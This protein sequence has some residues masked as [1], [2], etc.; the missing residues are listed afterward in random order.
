MKRIL[1]FFQTHRYAFIWTACYVFIMWAILLFLFNFDMFSGANW[2][3][4][5][6]SKLVGF[7]GFVFGILILA[8]IPLY[9][10]TTL[11]VVRNKSP[12]VK[13]KLPKFLQPVPA[14]AP[15]KPTPTPEPTTAP[16]PSPEKKIP[17]T[18][19]AELRVAYIRALDHMGNIQTS[20]FD[21]S[22]MTNSQKSVSTPDT[23]TQSTNEL[24]LPSDFE[25]PN[26]DFLSEPEMPNFSPMF[27]DLD[28]DSPSTPPSS[29][30]PSISE[31]SP[32]PD[33]AIT[34][35]LAEHGK[36]Y[37]IENGIVITDRDAIAIHDDPDFWIADDVNWFAAGQQKPSPIDT[38]LSI[39][40]ARGVRPVLYLA[41]TNILDLDAR[42]AQW[43]QAGITTITDLSEL[44]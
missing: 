22:N 11:I 16:A 26:E 32:T 10:A 6:H 23:P 17:D 12:L 38:L 29:G 27:Q 31:Q 44:N 1:E 7:P 5:S 14:S 20:A 18:V 42:R 13:I 24:P 40:A 19:P 9:I 28:F 39:S 43:R 3:R 21:L 30:V 37:T 41:Q 25:L 33:N 2:I 4:L 34:K 15:E 36:N 35:Y 8:A